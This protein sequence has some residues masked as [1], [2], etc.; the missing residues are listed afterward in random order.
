MTKKQKEEATDLLFLMVG[1]FW[2]ACFALKERGVD[3]AESLTKFNQRVDRL[4]TLLNDR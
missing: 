2:G 3:V 1:N 4:K